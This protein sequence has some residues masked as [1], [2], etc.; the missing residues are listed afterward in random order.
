MILILTI[1]SFNSN[2][3]M[4]M[5][6]KYFPKCIVNIIIS[7]FSDNEKYYILNEWKKIRYP[8]TFSSNKWISRFIKICP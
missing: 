1:C 5:P 8:V 6:Y 7:Q 4:E 3:N 2:G